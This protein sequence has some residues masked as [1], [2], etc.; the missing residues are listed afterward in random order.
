MMRELFN[1]PGG[2]TAFPRVKVKEDGTPEF[3]M[4]YAGECSDETTLQ[5]KLSQ[6]IKYLKCAVDV[7]FIYLLY[8]CQR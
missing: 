2:N 6:V 4:N 8:M 7:A 5:T 3:K 1:F